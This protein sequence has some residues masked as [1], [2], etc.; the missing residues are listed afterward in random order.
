MTLM[1]EISCMAEETF[2]VMIHAHVPELQRWTNN[3]S[4]EL[5]LLR[6]TER[7]TAGESHDLLYAQ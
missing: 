2:D 3:V 5:V 1:S 7:E 6:V 4:I